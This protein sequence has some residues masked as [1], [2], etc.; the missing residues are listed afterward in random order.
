MERGTEDYVDRVEHGGAPGKEAR[1][2]VKNE[3]KEGWMGSRGV[4]W[5]GRGRGTTHCASQPWLNAFPEVREVG[6]DPVVE[7]GRMWHC[8]LR[9]QVRM[10][11]AG[12][13]GR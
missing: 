3:G 7:T 8:T 6:W 12:S 10:A 4:G 1:E 2:R 11:G 5:G 9:V 13:Y